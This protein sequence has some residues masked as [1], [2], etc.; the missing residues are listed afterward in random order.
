M[1]SRLAGIIL[2]VFAIIALGWFYAWRTKPDMAETNRISVN[3]LAPALIFVG[4]LLGYA[5]SRLVQR[6]GDRR[7]RNRLRL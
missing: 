5:G 4:M 6:R 1:L 3:V 7:Q 2:P